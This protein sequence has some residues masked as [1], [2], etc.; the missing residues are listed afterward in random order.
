MIDCTAPM[1]SLAGSKHRPESNLE[2]AELTHSIIGAAMRVHSRLGCGF[3]EIIYQNALEFEFGK[4][5]IGYIREFEM[6]IYYETQLVGTRRVDFLVE[7]RIAVELKAVA[8]LE[9]IH[10]AQ[11]KNYLEAYGLRTGLLINFGS[12]SLEMKRLINSKASRSSTAKGVN[13]IRPGKETREVHT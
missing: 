10:L 3:Q 11:A 1:Q 4:N 8:A 7:E 12:K 5:G 9:D 13:P 2:D 6:P